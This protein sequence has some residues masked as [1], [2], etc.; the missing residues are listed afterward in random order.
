MFAKKSYMFQVPNYIA[1]NSDRDMIC[2]SYLGDNS[3]TCMTTDGDVVYKYE[4]E[5][6]T[7]PQGVCFDDSNKVLVCESD[8]QLTNKRF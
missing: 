6:M 8:S 1:V 2:V 4:A 5:D 7:Q 3:V